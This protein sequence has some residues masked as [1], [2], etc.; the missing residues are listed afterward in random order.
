[1]TSALARAVKTL[2]DGQIIDGLFFSPGDYTDEW[3]GLAK[4]EF[5]VRGLAEPTA[6]AIVQANAQEQ[7]PLSLGLR[8]VAFIFSPVF[9]GIPVLLAYR[10]YIE[11]GEFRKSR[12]WGR[13]AL[14]GL[15]FWI[16]CGFLAGSVQYFSHFG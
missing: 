8:S 1:M 6:E 5:S 15:A 9:L 12:E 11:R 2:S 10:H 13:Y 3:L 14:V 7:K 4:A 16:A